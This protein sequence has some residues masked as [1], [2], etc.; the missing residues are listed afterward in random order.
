VSQSSQI[1]K[2]RGYD[3]FCHSLFCLC[4]SSTF[5]PVDPDQKDAYFFLHSET[6]L[7]KN[8]HL[9]SSLRG[10][11]AGLRQGR[12]RTRP[13]QTR[14]IHQKILFLKRILHYF[15]DRHTSFAMTIGEASSKQCHK[16]SPRNAG[17]KEKIGFFYQKSINYGT[18]R[19]IIF[20]LP[21]RTT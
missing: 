11:R 6:S 19:Y 5:V 1:M 12:G 16:L 13:W 2:S 15:L 17:K 20:L 3:E 21:Y 9:R 4:D 10:L 7:N 18:I 8:K 14:L